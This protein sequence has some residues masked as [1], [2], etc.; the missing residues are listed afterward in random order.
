MPNSLGPAELLM[1]Y[2]TEEQKEKWLPKLAAGEAIGCYG[3][4]E[5]GAGSDAG[6]IATRATPDGDDVVLEIGTGSGYQ[7]AILSELAKKVVTIERIGEL[8]SRVKGILSKYKNVMPD[9]I[10]RLDELVGYTLDRLG[11]SATL[12]VMSD[13][14][15]ASW[16]RAMSMNS[17]PPSSA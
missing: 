8:S 2:G 11:D 6:S 13:H 14:G 9:I 15:F 1:H 10:V 3:L 4:T 17:W 7:A 5:E 12:I 16:R